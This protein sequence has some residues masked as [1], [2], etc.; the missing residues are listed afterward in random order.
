MLCSY[1]GQHTCGRIDKSSSWSSSRRLAIASHQY[2]ET[3]AA[4]QRR[5]LSPSTNCAH[6]QKCVGVGRV[7]GGCRETR[8]RPP[9]AIEINDSP[10][11]SAICFNP[12]TSTTIA[13][14]PAPRIRGENYTHT[15]TPTR[16]RPASGTRHPG[17]IAAIAAIT[18][19]IADGANVKRM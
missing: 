14:S 11:A 4:V 9:T 6:W 16:S 12:R 15:H 3:A 1:S 7:E 19:F 13:L 5:N 2:I 18:R 8:G 10:Q 17:A